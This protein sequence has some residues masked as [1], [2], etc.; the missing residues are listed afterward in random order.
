VVDKNLEALV[1]IFADRDDVRLV[2]V[3]DGPE[4]AALLALVE[5]LHLAERVRFLPPMER[6]R[7]AGLLR[8]A[9]CFVLNSGYE[10]HPHVVLEAMAVG[11][12]VAAADECGTPEVVR[13]DENGLLF[14]KDNSPQLVEALRRILDDEPTRKRLIEGGTRT[15]R[16]YAWSATVERTETLLNK[17]ARHEP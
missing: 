15:A 10:G 7:V 3:G 11:T 2:I 17:L 4:R 13:H 12:P 1:E 16:H 14:Q 9:S 6:A 8:L 5:R